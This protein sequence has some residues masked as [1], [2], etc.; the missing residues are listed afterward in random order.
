MLRA[1]ALARQPVQRL[2]AVEDIADAVA[3]LAS[4]RL[5]HHRRT[6]ARDRRRYA[7]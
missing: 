4:E 1:N 3:F 7:S 6:A 2:G 5:V